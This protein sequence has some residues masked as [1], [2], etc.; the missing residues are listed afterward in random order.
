M[1]SFLFQEWTWPFSISY[2]ITHYT[3]MKHVLK[4]K[5]NRRPSWKHRSVFFL[6][7]TMFE[8][9]YPLYNSNIPR[10]PIVV[11]EKFPFLFFRK[12]SF[13]NCSVVTLLHIDT[14]FQEICTSA[15][16]VRFTYIKKSSFFFYQHEYIKERLNLLHCIVL[17]AV[18]YVCYIFWQFFF[19]ETWR[20]LLKCCLKKEVL[21]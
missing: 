16:I 9:P 21:R 14:F 18:L 5:Q 12:C 4:V 13:R 3:S 20:N 7:R 8:H 19:N 1:T 17:Y 10:N 6:R 15:S 11:E 2:P